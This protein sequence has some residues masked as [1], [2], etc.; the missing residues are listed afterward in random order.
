VLASQ[1]MAEMAGTDLLGRVHELYPTAKR[2]LLVRWGDRASADPI[3]QAMAL[4]GFD[5]YVPKP[6]VFADEGFH[7]VVQG[8]LSE[9]AKAHGRAFAPVT[10][11]MCLS[12]GL[13]TWR[14]SSARQSTNWRPIP[15]RRLTRYGS[16][17]A[18][19]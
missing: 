2:G 19:S 7:T 15:E 17:T 5:Y 10:A 16:Q 18:V 8:F 3:L 4:G 11:T 14:P 13:H 12:N 1:W 9:W 6:A